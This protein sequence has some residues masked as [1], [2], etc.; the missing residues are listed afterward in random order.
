[1]Y[2]L[3]LPLIHIFSWNVAKVK[4]IKKF[5]VIS[6]FKLKV[7]TAWEKVSFISLHSINSWSWIGFIYSSSKD[8]EVLNLTFK[9]S[10]STQVMKQVVKSNGYPVC[11]SNV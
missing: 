9:S 2:F 7:D 11:L 1:M 5:L 3:W 4:S 10:L 6:S 8:A